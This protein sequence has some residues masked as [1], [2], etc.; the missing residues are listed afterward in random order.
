[1]Y[2]VYYTEN[3]ISHQIVNVNLII[4]LAKSDILI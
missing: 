2:I 4:E 1:M 3:I